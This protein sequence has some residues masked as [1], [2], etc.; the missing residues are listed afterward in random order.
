MQ[1]NRLWRYPPSEHLGQVPGVY[2]KV[3]I[4]IYFQGFFD[5]DLMSEVFVRCKFIKDAL[6]VTT[7]NRYSVHAQTYSRKVLIT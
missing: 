4:T 5:G 1:V 7:G 3:T 2:Y 6:T